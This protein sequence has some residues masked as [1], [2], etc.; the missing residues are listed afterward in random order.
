MMPKTAIITDTDSS[1]PQHLAEKYGIRQVPIGIHFDDEHFD[2]CD[3]FDDKTLFEYIDR[4][5]KL[6]TTSAPSPSSFIK[7]FEEAF[8]K[9][10]ESI[11]CICVSSKISSTYDAAVSAAAEFPGKKISVIDSLNLSMGQGY[12]VM[13]AAKAIEAGKSHE[14]AVELVMSMIGHVHIFGFLTTL[15]YMAMGGRV[16]KISASMANMLNILPILTSV[17]GKL[18]LLEKVRTKKR[19]LVRLSAL[20]SEALKDEPLV[21][22][23]F[24]HVNNEKGANELEKRL[25]KSLEIPEENLTTEFTPGL[26][27]HAGS[28]LVGVVIVTKYKD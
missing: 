19:A 1:L 11:I 26:S 23:A 16:S 8:S 14:E 13:E 20:V 28:G 22:I 9:G 24:I 17:D 15:K 7:Y 5:G 4:L 27:V 6:P 18:D 3:N 2:A 21:K 12:M 25:G 10:A